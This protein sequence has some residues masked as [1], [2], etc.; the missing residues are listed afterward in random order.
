VKEQKKKIGK[1]KI[2]MTC[3]RIQPDEGNGAHVSPTPRGMLPSELAETPE[4]GMGRGTNS[5]QD[6]ET[7]DN[8]IARRQETTWTEITGRPEMNAPSGRLHNGLMPLV[9]LAKLFCSMQY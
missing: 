8:G 7:S 5:G 6:P 1:G 9:E 4:E 3:C 2:T